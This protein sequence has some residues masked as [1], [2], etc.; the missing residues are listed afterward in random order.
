MA[1]SPSMRAVPPSD[2]APALIALD[3]SVTI[4]SQ[5]GTRSVPLGD[6]YRSDDVLRETVLQPDEL[7]VS[8]FVPRPA[9]GTRSV[10]LK[11]KRRP[12]HDFS[13]AS[14]AL[15]ARINDGRWNAVR[16]VLGSVAL[17]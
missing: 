5:Q 3:A 1:P 6:L 12:S 9:S 10:F 17:V 11:S 14:V 16:L 4:A 7:L 8:L 13:R 2:L 15:A